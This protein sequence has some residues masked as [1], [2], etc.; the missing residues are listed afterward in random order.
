[1]ILA[2]VNAPVLAIIFNA[3]WQKIAPRK[4]SDPPI[5]FHWLP[6]IGS[7]L[8]YGNDPINFFQTCQ[9]KVCF[10]AI[11]VYSLSNSEQYG[12]VFT[13]ILLGRKVT[14]ALSAKGSNFVLGGKS[15]S[16][17]A[18]GAYKVCLEGCFHRSSLTEKKN[19]T[20]T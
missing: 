8:W 15:T 13:F 7:A 18:E 19:E 1:M 3:L 16:F 2:L 10:S 11:R 14:V 12:N 5:V 6:I 4:A 9:E 20:S 17:N